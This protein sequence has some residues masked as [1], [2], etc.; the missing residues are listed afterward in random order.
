MQNQY[1]LCFF[2]LIIAQQRI[3]AASK[4]NSICFEPV[5]GLLVLLTI[6]KPLLVLL[7]LASIS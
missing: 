3:A 5:K 2:F 4:E 7:V 1:Y 6:L